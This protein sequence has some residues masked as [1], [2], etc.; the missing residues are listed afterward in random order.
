MRK[1]L[2]PF[3]LTKN[4][5]KNTRELVFTPALSEDN[6]YLFFIRDIYKS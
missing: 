4:N 5:Q 2:D 1:M 3:S 6:F